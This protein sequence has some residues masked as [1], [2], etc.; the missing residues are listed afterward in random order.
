MILQKVGLPIA[1]N[2]ADAS[3]RDTL[4]KELARRRSD[5]R[6]ERAEPRLVLASGSPRRLTLLGQ[7][8]I[9]PDALRPASID[10]TPRRCAKSSWAKELIVTFWICGSAGGND[11]HSRSVTAETLNRSRSQ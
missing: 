2:K 10:E 7:I 9:T 6:K 11:I 4:R 3:R 8:G 1:S 5:G